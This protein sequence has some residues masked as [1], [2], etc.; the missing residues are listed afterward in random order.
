M[1]DMKITG[2]NLGQELLRPKSGDKETHGF[3][4]VMK[5]AMGKISQ[6]QNDAEKAVKELASGG[7]VT[8]A[9]VAMEKADMSFQLMIAVRDKLLTAYDEI[10]RMQV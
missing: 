5:E 1:S 6:V 10:T 3:D 2:A 4:E 9:M 7:D 8:A